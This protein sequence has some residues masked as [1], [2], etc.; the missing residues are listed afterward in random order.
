VWKAAVALVWTDTSA[1]HELEISASDHFH[2]TKLTPRPRNSPDPGR[3]RP[4]RQRRP[5]PNFVKRV[6]VSGER[7]LW[8]RLRLEFWHGSVAVKIVRWPPHEFLYLMV[9][10]FTLSLVLV[11]RLWVC[12]LWRCWFINADLACIKQVFSPPACTDGDFAAE[13]ISR[14]R[15]RKLDHSEFH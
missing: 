1:E 12:L 14:R 3:I 4:I 6:S 7:L 11:A 5:L 13:I 10:L 15:T 8:L 9:R 2:A